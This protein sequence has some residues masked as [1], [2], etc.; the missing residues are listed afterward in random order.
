MAARMGDPTVHG[1]VIVVG[2]PTVLIGEVGSGGAGGGGGG[3]DKEDKSIL[4][5]LSSWI[6]SFF[7]S[8]ETK[9]SRVVGMDADKADE[10]INQALKN[11]RLLLEA[12]KKELEKWDDNAKANFKKAFGS[13][14][15]ENRNKIQAR[16][17]RMLELNKSMTL[18]N[19]KIA[20]P[21]DPKKQR[22]AY[23]IPSNNDHIVYLDISFGTAQDTGEDSRAGAL[24][25][26]MSHLNDIGGT[27]DKFI[28]INNDE[29]IY[30]LTA[31]R[32]LAV[33]HPELAIQ[34]ADSFEYYVENVP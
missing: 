31:S 22:F 12:K 33:E 11:Q 13:E 34:H 29:P 18:E 20:D 19:F 3:D 30:G 6:S 14:S 17:D 26:E 2:C 21:P 27:K 9:G 8:P 1:G 23:V 4:E 7:E 10:A 15:E 16:I 24:A 5:T 25:H 32:Q 28:G